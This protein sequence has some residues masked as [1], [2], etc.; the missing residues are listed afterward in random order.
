MGGG[1]L[2]NREFNIFVIMYIQS[3]DTGSYN[4]ILSE[5]CFYPLNFLL[6]HFPSYLCI[7]MFCI[8][9]FTVF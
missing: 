3:D 6:F 7:I 9:I 2:G 8:I 4:V 5:F 1:V